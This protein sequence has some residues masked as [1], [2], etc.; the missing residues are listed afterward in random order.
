VKLE[1]SVRLFASIVLAASAFGG[2]VQL[3]RFTLQRTKSQLPITAIL[4]IGVTA[5]VTGL[6]FVFPEVL[7]AF[8]RNREALLAGEW[9]RMVTP[10]FV[11]ASGWWQSCINGAGAVFVCPLAENIYG[12]RLLALYFVPGILGEIFAYRWDPTGAGSSL[13]IAGVMGGLFAFTFFYRSGNSRSARIFSIFGI[14]AA[15]VLS[16]SR[17]NHGPPILVGVLLASVMMILRPVSQGGANGRQPF[18]SD[19][20]QASAAPASRRSP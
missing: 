12:K 1:A 19:T 4:I 17:D 16:F 15:V 5:L 8:R 2:T 9:W 7:T 18:S 20:T 13:A 11:Q 10:L 3:Y 6:Q 14:A